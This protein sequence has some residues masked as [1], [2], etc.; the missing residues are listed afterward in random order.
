MPKPELYARPAPVDMAGAW[1]LDHARSDNIQE[2]LRVIARQ[3]QREAERRAR[4]AERG[5]AVSGGALPSGR[6]VFALAE[7]AELITAPTL[8]DV[9]QT[10][11]QIRLKRDNSFALICNTD[12]PPPS[13]SVTPFGSEQ[14]GWDGHQLF[15][16]IALPDNLLI[17]HRITRPSLTDVLVIRTAVYSPTVRDPFVVRKVFTRY[18]P[19]RAGYRCTQTLSRGKVCTTEAPEP[20]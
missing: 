13:V 18:Q 7:M 10:D 4:A 14:C 2:Q 5:Q 8:L 6:D 15:F 12:V 20:R 16:D 1:E 19:E 9:V 17:R 3:L 11:T